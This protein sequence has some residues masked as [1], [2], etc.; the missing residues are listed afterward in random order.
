L[1]KGGSPVIERASMVKQGVLNKPYEY[2]KDYAAG[3]L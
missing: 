1:V 3:K 2:L